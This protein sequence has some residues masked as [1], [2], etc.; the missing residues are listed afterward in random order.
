MLASFFSQKSGIPSSRIR[1]R[2]PSK[3]EVKRKPS[4]MYNLRNNTRVQNQQYKYI[5]IYI[6]FAETHG[7]FA[8]LVLNARLEQKLCFLAINMKVRHIEVHLKILDLSMPIITLSTW[9]K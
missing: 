3:Y 4:N 7:P 6:F 1:F 8:R 2:E 5:Y 9:K